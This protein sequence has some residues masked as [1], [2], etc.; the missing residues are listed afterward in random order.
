MQ[1]QVAE[2]GP[3][4]RTITITVPPEIVQQHLDGMYESATAQVQMR[5]FRPGKVPKK[6]IE[7]RYGS[8]ILAEAKEQMVNRFFGEACKQHAIQ[9]IGRVTIDEFDKLE[10]KQGIPLNFTVK[11]DVRPQFELKDP[12]GLEVEGYETETTDADLDK[13]LQE[14]ANQKRSIKKVDDAVQDGDF[15]KADLRFLDAAG[16]EAHARKGVQLNTRIPIAGSDAA[17]FQKTLIGAKAGQELTLELTFPENFEK[18]AIRGQKGRALLHVHEVLR[19]SPA[20]IDDALARGLEF[21]DLAAMK[22]DLRARIASEKVRMGKERQEQQCLQQ[23]LAANA[24]ALPA[25]LVEEQLHA[26]LQAFGQKLAENG[27]AKE[28]IEKKLE[29]TRPEAQQD[30]ERRVRLFFVIEAVARQQK[31]FVTETDIDAE[32]RSLAQANNVTPAQVRQHLEESKRYG[33]LR[34]ALLERKVRDFLRENAKIVDR[35]GK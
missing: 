6:L 17:E 11:L 21:E 33:E 5:G 10:V 20:P 25:S 29:E 18:E 23:L 15:A 35:K 7:K 27:M 8:G 1:V 22:T 12:K 19:V 3:C 34:L 24:F 30:A 31:I 28:D 32:L 13:A 4:S 14:V 16:N 9:P 2:T 26:S